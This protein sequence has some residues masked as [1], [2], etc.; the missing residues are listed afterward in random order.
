MSGLGSAV[1][2]IFGGIGGL[3]EAAAYGKAAKIAASNAQLTGVSTRIQE[4]QVERQAYQVI[5]AGQAQVAESFAGNN[6]TG[7]S[8]GDIFRSS[9]Q[10]AALAKGLTNIQGQITQ[11]GFEAQAAAYQGQ[12]AAAKAQGIG[13]IFGGI[14]GIA[15]AIFGI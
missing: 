10:Q 7:G 13:G 5:G 3:D 14:L 6:G 8:A 4:K 12:A 15:G 11:A 1:G 2:D 9:S